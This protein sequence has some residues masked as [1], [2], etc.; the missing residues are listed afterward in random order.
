MERTLDSPDT[1][2]REVPLRVAA[3][4]RTEGVPKLGQREGVGILSD[5]EIA[6]TPGAGYHDL[7]RDSRHRVRE[8]SASVTE[9]ATRPGRGK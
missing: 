7:A 6:I 1:A 8:R 3:A 9:S 2:D 4:A 5:H